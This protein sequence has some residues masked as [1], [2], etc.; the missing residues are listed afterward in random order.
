VASKTTAPAQQS[1]IGHHPTA[2]AGAD[3][4]V[5]QMAQALACAK[6]PFTQS[7]CDGIIFNMHGLPN[8][9]LKQGAHGYIFEGLDRWQAERHAAFRIQRAGRG[10][11]DTGK[12]CFTHITTD[13]SGGMRELRDDGFSRAICLC[14]FGKS[15][16]NRPVR[17]DERGAHL[18]ATQIKRNCEPG[19]GHALQGVKPGDAGR[20]IRRGEGERAKHN[21]FCPASAQQRHGVLADA[22]IGRQNNP[23]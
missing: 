20:Q 7:R 12:Q 19:H 2:D 11:A 5:N 4:D 1:A 8:R 16:P 23:V 10:Q 15:L 3:R 14:R 21:G 6:A 22:A 17:F 13:G 9:R 18:A